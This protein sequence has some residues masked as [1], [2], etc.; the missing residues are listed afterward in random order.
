MRKALRR[1]LICSRLDGNREAIEWLKNAVQ[2]HEPHAILFAGGILGKPAEGEDRSK[3]T[4]ETGETFK[5]FFKGLGDTGVYAAVIPGWYDQPIDEFLNLALDAELEFPNIHVV[6]GTLFEEGD[7]A[8]CGVGGELTEKGS[9]TGNHLKRSRAVAEYMLRMLWRSD[10]SRKVLLLGSPPNGKLGG[11][12]GS[13]VAG[14]I[15]DSYHPD[16]CAVGGETEHRG[17]DRVAHTWIVNPGRLADGSAALFDWN[18]PDGEK[19]ELL[20]IK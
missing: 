18:K 17:V 1:F 7:V 9:C 5:A 13:V 15:I 19:A 16:L 20:N 2:Q 3:L 4:N 11:S 10:V 14:E 8:L 6:H 12:I